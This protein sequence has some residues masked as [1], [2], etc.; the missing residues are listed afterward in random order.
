ML[1]E[2]DDFTNNAWDPQSWMHDLRS[3][4]GEMAITQV[5]LVGSHNAAS[6]GTR[7]DSPFGADAPGFLL[8]DSVFASLSRLLFRGIC[9]SWS[10]CQ[11][12]SVRAQ[13]DYGVRYL[14]LRVA[15][16]PED[17]SRLYISHTQI[18]VPLADVLEDVKAFLN[19]PLSA[20]EFIVLDFQHLYLTDDSDGKGKFFKELERLSDRFIPVDVPLTTPLEM[21][22]RVSRRRRIFLVVSSG[23]DELP[24]PA[25]RIRSK[26]MVSRWVDQGSLR[27]LL[28]AL[29]NLLLDDLKYPQ[30]GVPSK[31]HVTQAVYTP[32]KS[33]IFRGIFP[34]VSRKV[35]S[36]I[37]A[38]A[39][40]VNPSLLEWF[41]LLNAHGLLD[42]AK[43][44]IPS[45]I[46]T[47]GNIL[48]LDCVE[49]GRCQIM[50]GTTETNAV[51][52][53][54]Y[55][56]FLRASRLCEDSSAAPF[57]KEG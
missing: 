18:S 14:D 29:N 38:V 20:N 9:A 21:L 3:F 39:T 44:M 23:E 48:M 54:V 7:K 16:N 26:C 49:L 8:G 40:R 53:C 50:D 4:I 6:Y 43:V 52:M 41:Y 56:N 35:V 30:T 57:L 37:Y 10:R 2:S 55:L 19:D 22:W 25:V 27:K 15:T 5:C 47:H 51:G 42:G 11:W 45:G 33:N 13:L 1:P 12:M 17:A 46:N 34:K 36:S 31:L 24:Y 28:Q 32:R